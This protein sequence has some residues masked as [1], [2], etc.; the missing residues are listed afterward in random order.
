LKYARK[1][2]VADPLAFEVDYLRR[3]F[4]FAGLALLGIF[5]LDLVCEKLSGGGA[6]LAKGIS[7]LVSQPDIPPA[8]VTDTITAQNNLQT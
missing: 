4:A 7:V 6:T 2:L 8:Q 1:T 5:T 3:S